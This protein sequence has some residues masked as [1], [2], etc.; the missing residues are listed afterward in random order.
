MGEGFSRQSRQ[1]FAGILAEKDAL[2]RHFDGFQTHSR[3]YIILW[4]LPRPVPL[5]Q[6]AVFQGNLTQNGGKN[7][8]QTAFETVRTGS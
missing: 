8:V 6:G 7:P 2:R 4:S 3:L 1:I 5:G